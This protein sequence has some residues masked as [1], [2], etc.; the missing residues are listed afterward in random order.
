MEYST[1]T[2]LDESMRQWAK[3]TYDKLQ[4]KLGE[5]VFP[6]NVP[7]SID[8][9]DAVYEYPKNVGIIINE[10]NA[11][12]TEQFLLAAKQSKKVKLFGVTTAGALDISNMTSAESPCK[13]FRLWYC[14]SRSMRIPGMTIDDI[15]LQPDFYLD[16]TI[17]K[18]KWVEHVNEI[19]N[20]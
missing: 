18:Y 10:G 20:Q 6:F 3:N 7:V 5:F 11:S 19:L 16:K 4:E 9:Q 14:M 15:G 13:E 12:T 2:D 8:R 17:P 1:N